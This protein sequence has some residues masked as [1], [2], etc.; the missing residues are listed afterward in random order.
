MEGL[1]YDG[2]K[3]DELRVTISISKTNQSQKGKHCVFSL[4]WE[5]LI[6]INQTMV[7]HGIRK[8]VGSTPG[9]KNGDQER[10][11]VW[12]VGMVQAHDKLVEAFYLRNTALCTMTMCQ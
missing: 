9:E 7:W 3:M 8:R 12:K 5:S 10:R 2:W 6:Q 4:T 1:N 11:R